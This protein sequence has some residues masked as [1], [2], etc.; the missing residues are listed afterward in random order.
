MSSGLLA[1]VPESTQPGDAVAGLLLP[2]SNEFENSYLVLRPHAVKEHDLEASLTEIFCQ[3]IRPIFRCSI[4][5]H[6]WMEDFRSD[7]SEESTPEYR[8]EVIKGRASFYDTPWK[9][10]MAGSALQESF[11]ESLD[12]P[13]DEFLTEALNEAL[14]IHEPLHESLD[15]SLNVCQ[16]KS[17]DK[18]L[19]EYLD[20]SDGSLKDFEN[21][22]DEM[23]KRKITWRTFA[24]Q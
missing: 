18:S 19:G 3:R 17:L 5:G 8:S 13:L 15:K 10:I 23:G 20:G 12:E 7:Y 14:P 2:S 24:I 16:D 4:V 22:F 9:R 11:A 21:D 1:L 6:C